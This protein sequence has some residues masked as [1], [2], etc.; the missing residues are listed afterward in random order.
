M[1]ILQPEIYFT[2][3]VEG[4][5]TLDTGVPTTYFIDHPLSLPKFCF[6]TFGLHVH[7]SREELKK[8]DEKDVFTL[9]KK[10][11]SILENKTKKKVK[12]FRPGWL[13]YNEK[14]RKSAKKLDM[15][16]IGTNVRYYTAWF[17]KKKIIFITHSY[18]SKIFIRLLIFYL[19]LFHPFAE[20]KVF[21]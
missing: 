4:T 2:M 21:E 15:K 11:K 3:D 7:I 1:K 20:W 12:Y 18:D 10:R 16:I 14:I 13:V 5:S 17:P 8:L 19:K 9:I 6:D